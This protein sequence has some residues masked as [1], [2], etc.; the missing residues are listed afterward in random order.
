MTR[1][2]IKE[3]KGQMRVIEALIAC[4]LLVGGL[5]AATYLSSVNVSVEDSSIQ[6]SGENIFNVLCDSDVVHRVMEGGDFTEAQLKTL[7]STL[8]PPSSVFTVY[9]GSSMTN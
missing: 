7:I 2:T 5:S 6:E 8:L 3:N 9:F 4:L 1:R